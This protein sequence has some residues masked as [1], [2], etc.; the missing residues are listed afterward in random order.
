MAKGNSARPEKAKGLKRLKLA[1][2]DIIW[3][4]HAVYRRRQAGADKRWQ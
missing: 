1:Q 4:S 2:I 3:R